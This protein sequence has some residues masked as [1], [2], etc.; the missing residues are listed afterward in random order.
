MIASG[1][2]AA[3]LL[4]STSACRMAAR[5]A[6][7][8]DDSTWARSPRHGHGAGADAVVKHW[9]EKQP[10]RAVAFC[11]TIAHADVAAAFNVAGVPRVV[12][13]GDMPEAE[14]ALGPGCA[15]ARGGA[16]RRECRGADRGVGHPRIAARN[17]SA[18]TR[19]P[20]VHDDPGMVG[21]PGCA[22]WDPPSIPVSSSATASCWTSMPSS[23]DP[24]LPGAGC[25]SRQ[26]TWRG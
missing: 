26:R 21:H 13:T 17:R 5:C 15:D 1:P 8:G 3:Y 9:Q 20:Q 14:P 6:G 10:R 19:I 4:M 18:A 7:G 16:H 11:S 25:R 23:R 24:W 2:G 12:V 22:P